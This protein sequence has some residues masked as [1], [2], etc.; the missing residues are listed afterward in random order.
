MVSSYTAQA[1]IGESKLENGSFVPEYQLF[2]S[3]KKEEERLLMRTLNNTREWIWIPS[4]ECIL[5]DIFL[6]ISTIIFG[7]K[8]LDH[9]EMLSLMEYF[10]EKERFDAYEH[11][12]K[13][14]QYWHK[15][16]LLNIF[17]SSRITDQLETIKEYHCH[18]ELTQTRYIRS[19][20]AHSGKMTEKG[21]IY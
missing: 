10:T 6:M 15:K 5:D 8:A 20:D 18:I 13:R 16:V 2:F 12:K 19:S 11:A 14:S 7:D 3:E 4:R 9:P 17:E 21:S 1:L